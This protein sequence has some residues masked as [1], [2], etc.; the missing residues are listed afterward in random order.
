MLRA[1]KKLDSWADRYLAGPVRAAQLK[2]NR[3]SL[4]LIARAEQ[5]P[6]PSSRVTLSATQRDPLGTPRVELRWNMSPL[7]KQSIRTF[8]QVIGSE[9]RRLGLGD[10]RLSEWVQDETLELPYDRTVSNHPIGGFHHM[11]TTRMAAD[12]RHG[13]VDADCRVHGYRDLYVAGSSTFATSGW[14]NPTFTIVA[15]ALRLGDHLA[16]KLDK[17]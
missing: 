6:N 14:A 16:Q 2:L 12:P 5:A 10:V 7:D 8:A 17:A 11:G 4:F 1:Y 3:G 9:L 15:L 13:V